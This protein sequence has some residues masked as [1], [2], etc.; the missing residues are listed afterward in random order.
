M[1]WDIVLIVGLLIMFGDA[2]YASKVSETTQMVD[3]DGKPKAT[4]KG[5]VVSCVFA[6]SVAICVAGIVLRVLGYPAFFI[7]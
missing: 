7:S 5:K 3:V 4:V 1:M 2:I 6:L